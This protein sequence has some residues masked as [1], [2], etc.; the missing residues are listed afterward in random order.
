MRDA[1]IAPA[2]HRQ[3]AEIEP[4]DQGQ[5][6]RHDEVG[7]GDPGHGGRHHRVVDDAV[8]PQGRERSGREAEQGR[9]QDR[10]RAELERNRETLPDQ[11]VD[12]EILV[13]EGRPEIGVQK[14]PQIA[15][16]LH[17]QR[18]VEMIGLSKLGLD[19]GGNR[20][21]PVEGAARRQPDHE[22]RNGDNDEQGRDCPGDSS[23]GIAQ[24]G[25]YRN[26]LKDPAR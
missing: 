6:R 21:L 11:L 20:A 10:R 12:G 5:K 18:L 4:E 19:L 22:E 24:H 15:A 1:A 14:A 17:D 3:E 13:L 9:Q 25:Q 23:Q 2:A 7:D 26:M 16:V 8:L